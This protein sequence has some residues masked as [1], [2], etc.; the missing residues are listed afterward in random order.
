[1]HLPL[2]FEDI[3]YVM[4]D[5]TNTYLPLFFRTFI[6]YVFILLGILVCY[7]R[8]LYQHI[9]FGTHTFIFSEEVIASPNIYK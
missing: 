7:K 9:L 8:A 5:F 2:S 1:M 3:R 4:Y 6:F